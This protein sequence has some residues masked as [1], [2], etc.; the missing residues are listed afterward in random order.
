MSSLG[1]HSVQR[2]VA[3]TVGQARKT[4]STL[5]S[6]KLTRPGLPSDLKALKSQNNQKLCLSFCYSLVSFLTSFF[7][8]IFCIEF[9][10]F[11]SGDPSPKHVQCIKLLQYLCWPCFFGKFLGFLDLNSILYQ[12]GGQFQIDQDCLN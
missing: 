3:K 5:V 1:T 9:Q 12:L 7:Y 4:T 2:E 11:L 10:F 8:T 6:H